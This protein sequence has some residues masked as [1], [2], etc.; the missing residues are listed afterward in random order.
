MEGGFE[1]APSSIPK[2][3]TAIHL[4]SLNGGLAR[5]VMKKANHL[6]RLVQNIS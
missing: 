4:D 1:S 2:Q 5:I 3:V 6:D